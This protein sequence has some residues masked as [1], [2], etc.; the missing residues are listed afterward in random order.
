MTRC[1]GVLGPRPK[2]CRLKVSGALGPWYCPRCIGPKEAADV[3]ALTR[4]QLGGEKRAR[5]TVCLLGPAT[6]TKWS[7]ARWSWANNL[8]ALWKRRPRKPKK[9]PREARCNLLMRA[10][11]ALGLAGGRGRGHATVG[12]KKH[13]A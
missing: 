2:D 1:Y 10:R 12:V 11:L 13:C 9:P 5:E 7:F 3:A 4:T 6:N 8:Y